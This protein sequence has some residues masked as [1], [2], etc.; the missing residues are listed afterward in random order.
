MK[1]SEKQALA[2]TSAAESLVLQEEENGV[3]TLTLNRPKQF[4]ALSEAMLVALQEKLEAIAEN[5]A[6]R[7]VI[8]QGAAKRDILSNALQA[9]Q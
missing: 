8:L 7:L 5:E 6:V 1:P 2:T 4:N 3:A 9:M